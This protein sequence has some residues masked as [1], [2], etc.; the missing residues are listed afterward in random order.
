MHSPLFFLAILGLKDC[1]YPKIPWWSFFLRK[2]DN[3]RRQTARANSCRLTPV[4]LKSLVVRRAMRLWDD[5]LKKNHSKWS[6]D[7]WYYLIFMYICSDISDIIWYYLIYT[8][9]SE[10]SISQSLL[11]VPFWGMN[12]PGPCRKGWPVG[13][14]IPKASSSNVAPKTPGRRGIT[15]QNLVVKWRKK[16]QCRYHLPYLPIPGWSNPD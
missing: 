4:G 9:C 13:L 12:E 15:W 1:G 3:S 7:N 8:L 11:S 5:P 14:A 2:T 16:K 10:L 6:V